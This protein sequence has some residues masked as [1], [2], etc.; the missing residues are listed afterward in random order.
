MTAVPSATPAPP[1]PADAMLT[2]AVEAIA[3]V[4]FMG[5]VFISF[6]TMADVTLR[7]LN[8]PRIPGFKD[9]NEV[10]YALVVASCFPAGLK[11]GN[12]VT[13]RL[14]GQALGRRWHALFDVVG[15][16]LTL[17]FFA[18][19][20]W[21]VGELAALRQAAGRTTSTLEWSTAPVWWSVCVLMGLAALVQAWV[22]AA[23]IAAARRGVPLVSADAHVTD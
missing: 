10:V 19:V 5:L 13:V 20:T 14:L 6:M 1:S 16:A 11:K 18:L 21:Q 12:A 4:G 2:R 7:Y 8:L 23:T 9:L 17:A 15:A 3:V 22:L